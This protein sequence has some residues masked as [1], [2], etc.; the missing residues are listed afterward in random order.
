MTSIH[1]KVVI[2][3]D[4]NSSIGMGHVV[5]SIALGHMLKQEFKIVFAIQQPGDSV[6]KVIKELTDEIILLP[7][8]TNYSDDVH[9]FL[10]HI[11]KTDIVVIDGYDFKSE[12]Q[13]T[14]KL[15]GSK[16]VCI[17]DLHDWHHVADVIINYAGEVDK[18]DYSTE[19]YTKLFLGLKYVLLRPEFLKPAIPGK[20]NAV[21][22]IFISMGASDVHNVTKKFI[23]ALSPISAIEEIDLLLG[24]MNQHLPGIEELINRNKLSKVL[25]YIDIDGLKLKQLLQKCDVA[26]CPASTISLECCAT[27][28]GLVSGCTAPNQSGI[29]NMLIKHNAAVDFGD[30]KQIS[31]ES[32]RGQIENLIEQPEKFNTQI[33]NQQEMIDGNSPARILN[34]FTDLARE[35][36]HFRF[37]NIDDAKLYFKWTN[38]PVVRSNSF[39]QQ[40]VT[41]ENHVKWFDSKLNAEY[42]KLYLFFNNENSPVGQVR[43]DKSSNDLII[44]ISVDAAFRGKSYSTEMLKKSTLDYFHRYPASVINAYIKTENTASYNVFLRAGFVEDKIVEI[45]GTRSYRMYKKKGDE[46]H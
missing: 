15:N 46:R 30:L 22:K 36:L 34:I 10:P 11:G 9:N 2:R 3:A 12:Y 32:I 38:D 14:I 26:I 4:S 44:G 33:R 31:I 37:A 25:T 43:I 40:P 24:S 29:L 8:T 23:E 41:Y 19:S 13:R 45:Q 27:G 21:S 17:D 20:I 42:C 16:L 5:R 7:G 6:L 39:N 28:I 35:R 1:P 18:S